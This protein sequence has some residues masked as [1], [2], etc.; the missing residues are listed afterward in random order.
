MP[1]ALPV[2]Q[3]AVLKHRWE[4]TAITQTTENQSLGSSFLNAPR[5][6]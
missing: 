1:H 4:L 3:P 5:D 6:S 2:A